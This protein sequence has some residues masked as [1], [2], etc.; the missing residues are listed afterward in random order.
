M[1]PASIQILIAYAGRDRQVLRR[2]EVA[3][4]ATVAESIEASGLLSEFPEI[5]LARNK[6]GIFGRLAPH[7]TSVQEGDRIE[8]YR[9]LTIEPT[10][11]RRRRAGTRG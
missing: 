6:V 1:K 4:D 9:P 3:R 8:I 10:E 2:L 7:D 5:D 11:A